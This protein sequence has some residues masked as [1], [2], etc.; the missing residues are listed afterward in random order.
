MLDTDGEKV[1]RNPFLPKKYL[2]I[3]PSPKTLAASASSIQHPVSCMQVKIA[4]P[5]N[6]DEG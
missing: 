4:T 5:A 1:Y 2:K 3:I 6:P